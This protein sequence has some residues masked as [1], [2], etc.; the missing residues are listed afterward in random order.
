MR[1]LLLPMEET[2]RETPTLSYRDKLIKLLSHDLDFHDQDSRYASHNFHSFPAKFPPQL[3]RT[4]ITALTEPGDIVLDPMMGSGTTILEA[5]LAERHGFGFD[6]DPLALRITQ[7]K[8]RPLRMDHLS[9]LARTIVVEAR[10]DCQAKRAALKAELKEHWNDETKKFVDYW[11]DPEIQIELL[12]IIKK[13]NSLTD[14]SAKA[15]F[16]LAFSAIIITKTGGISLALDL[17][18]TRPHRAKIV[19]DRDG[20]YILGRELSDDIVNK[21]RNLTKKL[22][23][24]LDEFERRVQQN[25]K[26]VLNPNDIKGISCLLT[27]SAEQMPLRDSTVDL[28]VT[29]PPYAS[30]AIDYM[31]AHKFA[32]VWLGYVLGELSEKR[33]KYIGGEATTDAEL[34]DMP[35]Y[36]AGIIDKVSQ[37]DRNRGRVLHRYYSEMKKVLGEMFRVLKPNKS[38]I[39]VVGSSVMRE[40]DTETG[41]CLAEI[42][43]GIGF[44]IAKIGVRRLDR[45]RR[46]LPAGTRRNL[47]SQIQQRMHEEYVIGFYKP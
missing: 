10:H 5:L 11:F 38:A 34:E 4:F 23:S 1:Q 44:D 29:S 43:R 40:I 32:L 12:A 14:E 21:Y 27:G 6:I 8:V 15:F 24:P 42:G 35:S 36:V 46:M 45:D 47:Q 17:G 7:V 3:P 22:R 28:I 18:H 33:K 13:I 30:N 9:Q 31:R 19:L 37:R 39:V 16:V 41:I 20:G 25:L 26:G 2:H